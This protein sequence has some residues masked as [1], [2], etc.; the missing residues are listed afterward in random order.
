MNYFAEILSAKQNTLLFVTCSCLLNCRLK[1][2]TFLRPGL[3]CLHII[4]LVSVMNP[5]IC[6]RK[7]G[8]FVARKFYTCTRFI[9]IENVKNS[10]YII[11]FFRM[12]TISF[13][14]TIIIIIKM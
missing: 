7:T 9:H 3:N 13:V 11:L 6:T 4:F 12:M 2:I 10:I 1:L 8:K 14:I 5:H